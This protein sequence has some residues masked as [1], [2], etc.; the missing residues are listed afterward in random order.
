MRALCAPLVSPFFVLHQFSVDIT[1]R[2][3]DQRGTNTTLSPTA[4]TRNTA[5]VGGLAQLRGRSDGSSLRLGGSKR[6]NAAGFLLPIF[7]T[8]SR[9]SMDTLPLVLIVLHAPQRQTYSE[10]KRTKPDLC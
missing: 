7:V 2:L 4:V 10:N 1:A 6:Y 3:P 9:A 5:G 8:L